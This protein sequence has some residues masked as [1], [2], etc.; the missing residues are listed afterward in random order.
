MGRGGKE[1]EKGNWMGR[2]VSQRSK[3][4]RKKDSEYAYSARGEEYYGPTLRLAW[5]TVT[6]AA[7]H[8]GLGFKGEDANRKRGEKCVIGPSVVS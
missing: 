8:L 5:L 3:R 6:L 4:T 7:D 1:V 2:K